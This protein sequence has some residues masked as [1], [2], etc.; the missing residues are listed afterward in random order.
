VFT[1]IRIQQN[2]AYVACTNVSI[3]T[4]S[5]PE[6]GTDTA[7][8]RFGPY[9]GYLAAAK[10]IVSPWGSG[11]SAEPTSRDVYLILIAPEGGAVL[12]PEHVRVALQ[13]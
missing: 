6:G 10:A 9:G 13:Y 7:L 4:I 11:S 1:R 5:N 3:P 2:R 12:L 8:E